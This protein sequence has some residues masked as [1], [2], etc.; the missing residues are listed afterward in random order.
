MATTKLDVW[1]MCLVDELGVDPLSDTG[2]A[3]EAGRVLTRLHDKAV[4][5][6]LS[7][8]S[9]NFATETVKLDADT[10]VVPAFGYP[11]VFGKPPDWVR[12]VAVSEDEYFTYPLVN[13]YDDASYWSA[14]NTPV[15]VRYVSDDTGMGFD[16]TRWTPLFARYVA[17]E[18]ASRSCMKLTQSRALKQEVDKA[19]DKARRRALNQD[20]LDEAQ[21]KF[22]PPNSWTQSRWSG[23]GGPHDRGSRGRLIG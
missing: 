13:Y 3:N 18:L 4:A 17:S 11:K 15:Y 22:A 12:T 9:W 20:A 2:E 8:G 1:N 7:V 14:D 23:N 5:E 19:R 16:M 6:C 10:G 21:P